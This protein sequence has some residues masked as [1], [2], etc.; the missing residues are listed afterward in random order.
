M[1]T[2]WGRSQTVTR[3]ADGITSV[4]TAGHGGIYA[5]A[6]GKLEA[7]LKADVCESGYAGGGE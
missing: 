2:P 5:E 7:C 4:S 1:E 3:L 6:Y